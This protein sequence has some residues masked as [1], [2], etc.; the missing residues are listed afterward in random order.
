MFKMFKTENKIEKLYSL[1]D[2][3]LSCEQGVAKTLILEDTD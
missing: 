2:L 1:L 3:E